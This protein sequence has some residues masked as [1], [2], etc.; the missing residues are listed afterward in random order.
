MEDGRVLTDNYWLRAQ[1]I[2]IVVAGDSMMRQHFTRLVQM[3]R[4]RQRNIDYRVHTHGSY[5][6][7]DEVRQDWS[8][9]YTRDSRSIRS[10]SVGTPWLDDRALMG[11]GVAVLGSG[12][13]N[14]PFGSNGALRTV[15]SDDPVQNLPGQAS[16][17][18]QWP[19]AAG[20][21]PSTRGDQ[22]L[23]DHR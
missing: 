16:Y 11:R 8:R 13:V 6:Y 10:I 1:N 18:M 19:A 22:L 5:S 15:G 3:L 2:D 7:C 23:Y 9:R 4:G 12:A 20:P 14:Q 17:S 21:A